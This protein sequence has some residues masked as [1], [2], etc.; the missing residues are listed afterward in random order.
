M[1]PKYFYAYIVSVFIFFI[2]Y[3]ILKCVYKIDIFDD[4]LYTDK[5]NATIPSYVIY[6]LSHF[7]LYFV[8]GLIFSFDI[9]GT[10]A[11]KTVIIEILLVL[12]KNCSITKIDHIESAM[13]SIVIGMLSYIMGAVVS[14][15]Y[16]K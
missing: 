3:S 2:L 5:T 14:S 9:L 15:F 16:S 7:V 8:F 11:I 13:E 6:Y 4:F 1:D 12:I 10:M